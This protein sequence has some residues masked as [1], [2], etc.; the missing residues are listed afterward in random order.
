MVA[1]NHG[2]DKNHVAHISEKDIRVFYPTTI[3]HR[4]VAPHPITQQSISIT[5][6]EHELIVVRL[7]N[8]N[9]FVSRYF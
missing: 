2:F 4:L 5:V 6:A 9:F 3:A 7:Q 8:N 1:E